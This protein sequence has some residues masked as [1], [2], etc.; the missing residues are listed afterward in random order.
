MGVALDLNLIKFVY[1]TNGVLRAFDDIQENDRDG[2]KGEWLMEWGV[3]VNVPKAHA[4][5]KNV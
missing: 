3:Q 2:R 1:F 4:I 5:I